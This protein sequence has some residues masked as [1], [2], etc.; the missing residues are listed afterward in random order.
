M[1]VNPPPTCVQRTSLLY[2]FQLYNADKK[3]VFACADKINNA[4]G[5]ILYVFNIFMHYAPNS[6]LFIMYPHVVSID[7]GQYKVICL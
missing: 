6:E 2:R 4:Y 5:Y 3:N 7:F 1:R